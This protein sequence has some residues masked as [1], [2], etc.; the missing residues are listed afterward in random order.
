MNGNKVNPYEF[1]VK[2]PCDVIKANMEFL[3]KNYKDVINSCIELLND[4]IDIGNIVLQIKEESEELRQSIINKY[5]MYPM[6]LNVIYPNL[7]F[8]VTGLLLGAL[9]Q[10]IFSLRLALE[11]FAL[12][13]YADND[14]KLKNMIWPQKME[15]KEVRGFRLGRPYRKKLIAI[16]GQVMDEREAEEAVGDI[17]G[18]F[19]GL[20]AWIH[21]IATIRRTTERGVEELTAG[22]F[23]A[24]LLTTGEKGILPSY[25]ILIPS[26]YGEADLED[27]RHLQNLIEHVRSAIAL[28]MYAWV[29]DKDFLRK[30]LVEKFFNMRSDLDSDTSKRTEA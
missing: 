5:L 13:L 15:Q 6:L 21:P 22:L 25:G 16:F 9:P 20:S 26:K 7:L 4:I 3:L 8:T 27:L 29:N 2:Y 18:V 11:A 14:P 17:L 28:M 12:A 23:K 1:Y 10:V 19:K 24:I 30:G